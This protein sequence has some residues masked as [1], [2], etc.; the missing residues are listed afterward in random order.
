[1]CHTQLSA[2]MVNLGG[3]LI[4]ASIPIE[5]ARDMAWAYV[6]SLDDGVFEYEPD[7]Q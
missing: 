2:L 6:E 5:Q 1:M 7:D 4:D 3:P